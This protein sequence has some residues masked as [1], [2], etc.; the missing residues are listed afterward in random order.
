MKRYWIIKPDQGEL[1][2]YLRPPLIIRPAPGCLLPW[3]RVLRLVPWLDDLLNRVSLIS[4]WYWVSMISR[5][6]LRLDWLVAWFNDTMSGVQVQWSPRIF[7]VEK[8]LPTPRRPKILIRSKMS[9]MPNSASEG[10]TY[11][12]IFFVALRTNNSRVFCY[13]CFFLPRGS[14][15]LQC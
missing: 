3:L 9:S 5:W 10:W 6:Y 13:F 14:Q 2:C 12:H 8:N 1:V 4:V 15:M 7:V 11:G